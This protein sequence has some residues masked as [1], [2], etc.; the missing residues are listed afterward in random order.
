MRH[1]GSWKRRTIWL[2]IRESLR[3]RVRTEQLHHIFHRDTAPNKSIL[4][5]VTAVN[6]LLAI[7]KRNTQFVRHLLKTG[8]KV[9]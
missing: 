1:S 7:K 4:K 3:T 2:R 9:Q 8:R 5:Q 6:L